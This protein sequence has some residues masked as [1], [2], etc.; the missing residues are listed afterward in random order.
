MT[1]GKA[2]WVHWKRASLIAAEKLNL[3]SDNDE[4]LG[5]RYHGDYSP[6]EG[7]EARNKDSASLKHHQAPEESKQVDE[8]SRSRRPAANVSSWALN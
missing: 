2:S 7:F 6:R 3:P 5:R 4:A 8:S 1:D